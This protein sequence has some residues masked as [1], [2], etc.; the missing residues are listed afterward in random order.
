M[1]D[2][3]NVLLSS[4]HSDIMNKQ[5][6]VGL[7]FSAASRSGSISLS[8]SMAVYRNPALTKQLSCPTLAG[9]QEYRCHG[10]RIWSLL[11]TMTSLRFWYLSVNRARTKITQSGIQQSYNSEISSYIVLAKKVSSKC[12]F[13]T[14]MT[15]CRNIGVRDRR[16]FLIKAFLHTACS[17]S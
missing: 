10:R 17:R 13:Q 4:G 9:S 1:L 14:F 15:L 11:K 6:L 16:F 8:L 2:R 3:C 7:E 5:N 12:L